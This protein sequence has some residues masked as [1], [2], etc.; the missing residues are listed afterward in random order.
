MQKVEGSS[1]FSRFAQKPHSDGVFCCPYLGAL[2]DP[3]R[4]RAA[5]VRVGL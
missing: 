4:T 1:P 3:F 2:A 5:R